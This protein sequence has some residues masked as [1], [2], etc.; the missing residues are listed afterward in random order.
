MFE[1]IV[2]AINDIVWSPLLVILLIFAGLFFSYKT[3][4]VQ[5]RRLGLLVKSLFA[6]GASNK[7]EKKGI[8]SFEAFC[9]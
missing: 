3:G 5:V 4:F 2:S 8:S 1:K 6:S 7:E 9:V